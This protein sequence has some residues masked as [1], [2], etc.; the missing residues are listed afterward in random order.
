MALSSFSSCRLK[1]SWKSAFFYCFACVAVIPLLNPEHLRFCYL[2]FAYPVT[3]LA[4]CIWLVRLVSLAF[5]S[6]LSRQTFVCSFIASLTICA[7]I[8]QANHSEFRVFADE[9]ELLATSRAMYFDKGVSYQ[10]T[11]YRDTTRARMSKSDFDIRPT[12]YPFIVH[13]FHHG[14]GYQPQ[15]S[16]RANGLICFLLL[17]AIFLFVS[18]F[19]GL[20]GALTATLFV[21]AHPIV[22]LTATSGGYDLTSTFFLFLSLTLSYQVLQKRSPQLEALLEATL[23]LLALTRFESV[24]Y[25]LIIG[26]FFCWSNV[27]TPKRGL[28]FLSPIFLALPVWLRFA[29]IEHPILRSETKLFSFESFL[30]NNLVFLKSLTSF[31]VETFPFSPALH[32]TGLFGLGLLGVKLFQQRKNI[33]SSTKMFA[34]LLSTVSVTCWIIITAHFWSKITDPFVYRHY[35][36]VTLVLSILA[37]P[38]VVL[39]LRKLRANLILASVLALFVFVLSVPKAMQLTSMRNGR[40]AARYYQ[41]LEYLKQSKQEKILVIGAVPLQY[42]VNG[43]DALDFLGANHQAQK[44]I[45]LKQQKIYDRVFVVQTFYPTKQRIKNNERLSKSLADRAVRHHEEVLEYYKRE[46]D[47]PWLK[48]SEII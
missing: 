27:L 10:T 47:E 22:A 17:Q 16:I 18:Q 44:I 28:F 38:A 23:V 2:Q 48:I 41:A 7:L 35:L 8:F 1:V 32:L 40:F 33:S 6:K 25:S 3:V 5:H 15:N 46:L 37:L 43:F 29:K 39:V 31:G 12:L 20:G 13:L 26:G 11:S 36:P 14:L 21:A 30:S 4:F 42:T 34:L 9:V 19:Y 24:L 45:E